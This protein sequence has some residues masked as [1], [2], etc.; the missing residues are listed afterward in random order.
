[1]NILH[2]RNM[3]T[4][5][6]LDEYFILFIYIAIFI[7]SSECDALDAKCTESF[8]A[9]SVTWQSFTDDESGIVGYKYLEYQYHQY[10]FQ[11]NNFLSKIW[12]QV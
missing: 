11:C 9:L 2:L 1:M 5:T 6:Y 4:I 7:Y 10:K 8:S 3:K 12:K